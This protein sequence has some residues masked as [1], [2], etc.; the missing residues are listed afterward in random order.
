LPKKRKSRGRSKGS[1]GRGEIIYCDQCG[2][3]IPRDKAI[4]V[5]RYYYPV[6]PQLA[7]EL[8]KQGARIMKVPVTKYYCVS[9]AI[10]L[11]IRKVRAKGERRASSGS[12]FIVDIRR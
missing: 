9:C 2:R 3:A 12:S 1:K 4:K 11:G 6:D 8:E 5:T 10:Y 7:I